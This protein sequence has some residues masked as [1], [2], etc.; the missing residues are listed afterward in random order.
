MSSVIGID[1]GTTRTKMAVLTPSGEPQVLTNR[2]GETTTASVVY[3]NEDGT[4]LIGTEAANAA[5]ACPDRAVD[6]F[7]VNMGTDKVLYTH[8]DGTAYRAQDIAA[9][10]LRQV[11][12][13]AEAKTGT[14]VNDVVVTVPANYSNL[15]K[16][17]TKD[18]AQQAGMNAI[19]L[20]HEPTAA[21]LGNQLY[22]MK[23]GIALV[24]DLGGGTFDVSI[25]K[26]QGNLTEVVATEGIQQLGGRDFNARL[27]ESILAGF[28]KEHDYRPD[29]KKHAVFYQDLKGRVEQLKINLSSQQKCSVVLSCNGDVLT[30]TL[31]RQEFEDHVRD[32]VD[33][34]IAKTEQ[35]LQDAGLNWNQVDAIYPV[36][37]GAMM[38]VVV[39][40]LE[41]ASGKKV[42]QLCE[43]HFAAALGAAVAARIKYAQENKPIQVGSVT[44]P[45]INFFTREILSRAVGVAA[46]NEQDQVICSEIL[47]KQTPI[48]SIQTQRFK[49]TEPGQTC[50]KIQV[51]QGCHGDLAD[52]CDCMGSFDLKNLPVRPD[53]IDRIEITFDI[54]AN[55]LLKAMA[56][57]TVSNTQ[58]DLDID[59]KQVAQGGVL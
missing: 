59:V 35:T 18:A 40:S 37:G 47:A 12:A 6:H 54:D 56:R 1:L 42:T 27:Q 49:L 58:S 10:L 17:Q 7:K 30:F 14:P 20:P 19:L 31:T 28:E 48:P 2:N 34:T 23:Q 50:V 36:G 26:V 24:Y 51:L 21:A 25:I 22:K 44:L 16:Q 3:F 43:A 46:L 45:P 5:L 52:T 15:Q 39:A 13:D 53:V 38:P 9:L 11:K 33:Q 32:L 29:P 57:D 4:V 55:G 41:Q 8:S